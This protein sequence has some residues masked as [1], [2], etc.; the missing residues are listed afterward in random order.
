MTSEG[1]STITE[2][3]LTVTADSAPT[4]NPGD[5]ASAKDASVCRQTDRSDVIGKINRGGEFYQ[6]DVVIIGRCIVVRVVDE[7]GDG[8]ELLVRIDT[9]LGVSSEVHWNATGVVGASAFLPECME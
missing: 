3:C 5:G 1:E 2:R 6:W 7:L 9:L 8:S 4:G